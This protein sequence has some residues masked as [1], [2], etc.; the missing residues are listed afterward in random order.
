MSNAGI[1][2]QII[3]LDFEASGSD[4]WGKHAPT[5]V[6]LAFG[7]EMASWFFKWSQWDDSYEWDEEA[8]KVHQVEQDALNKMG[9]PAFVVD[10]HATSWLAGRLPKGG[11]MNRLAVGWNVAGYDRQF[12]TRHMPGLNSML[13]YRTIDLNALCF[14]LEGMGGHDWKYWKRAAKQFGNQFI[15]ETN[16]HDAGIDARVA[17]FE[18]D[19]LRRK[20]TGEYG[21]GS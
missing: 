21:E 7:D 6:G 12:V 1:P 8:Y 4:P 5:Q 18:L 13:S 2:L 20:I 17:L 10:A 3:G 14:A 15:D 19:F 11:R 16:R 9:W